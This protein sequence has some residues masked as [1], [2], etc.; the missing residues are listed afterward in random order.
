MVNLALLAPDIVASIAVGEQP[1]GL[2]TDYL[3]KNQ[4]PP[5]WLDQRTQF[6]AL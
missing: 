2:T 4:F 1:E 3:I 5:S 6:A